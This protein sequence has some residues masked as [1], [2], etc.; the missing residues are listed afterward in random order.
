MSDLVHGLELD[1]REPAEG[2]LATPA[3]VGPFDPD[4][5][6]EAELVP[7]PPAL[8]VEDVAL[9]QGEERGR[10]GFGPRDDLTIHAIG[11]TL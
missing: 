5:D 11:G 9:Q 3:V 7:R 4:H 6:R 1:R 8:P 10:S 2:T